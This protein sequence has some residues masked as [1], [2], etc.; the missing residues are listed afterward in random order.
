MLTSTDNDMIN[1]TKLLNVAGMSR[2]KRD[3]ILKGEKIRSVVKIGAMHLKG[4][5]AIAAP[6]WSICSCRKSAFSACLLRFCS[7]FFA[8]S[9][10]RIPFE[11]AL[12]F[13]NKERITDLLYPL[14]VMNIKL[15]LYHPTNYARTTAVM[16]AA[17]H[18]Q[19]MQFSQNRHNRLTELSGAL[20]GTLSGTLA[21][22]VD[23]AAIG[24]TL[25]T[26]VGS[27][28]VLG[29]PGAVEMANEPVLA[30]KGPLTPPHSAPILTHTDSHWSCGTVTP[31]RPYS[32]AA[33]PVT[34]VTPPYY[35]R[36]CSQNACHVS[37][38]E[39]HCQLYHTNS[40][41]RRQVYGTPV[42]QRSKHEEEVCSQRP[43]LYQEMMAPQLHEHSVQTTPTISPVSPVSA[44]QTVQTVPGKPFPQSPVGP[45]FLHKEEF[46]EAALA[47]AVQS[48]V[49]AVPALVHHT[50]DDA[51]TINS[52][53]PYSHQSTGDS[54]VYHLSNVTPVPHVLNKVDSVLTPSNTCSLVAGVNQWT[55]QD[56]SSPLSYSSP[57]DEDS[58]V[59]INTWLQ[60]RLWKEALPSKN[61]YQIAD[62]KQNINRVFRS[63]SVDHALISSK[64]A[65]DMV[66]LC[67][68]DSNFHFD[69]EK[70]IMESTQKKEFTSANQSYIKQNMLTSSELNPIFSNLSD[71]KTHPVY[72]SETAKPLKRRKTIHEEVP[73]ISGLG[74]MTP[75]WV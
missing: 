11:R 58:L 75:M 5:C 38:S 10:C 31:T 23:A 22:T 43:L 64:Y 39:P 26:V 57:Q 48:T 20:S 33:L 17:Q 30:D 1:G 7:L 4:V 24:M 71:L 66:N 62:T 35:F 25:G 18:F 40:A 56:A 34:P 65:R 69:T 9:M 50:A 41:H 2:G 59:Q 45:D 13:A 52:Q 60:S 16:A 32:A 28:R 37:Y 42:V 14:F 36:S 3:G 12:E 51:S 73:S 72:F 55:L 63:N 47:S 61:F 15:F 44:I 19:M 67:Q 74:S 21:G 68:S 8:Y 27:S 46:Y 29:A 54:H 53:S 49:S 70:T 6:W